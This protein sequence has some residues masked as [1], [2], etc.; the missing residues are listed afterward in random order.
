MR[1]NY[2][3]PN[4]TDNPFLTEPIYHD[5]ICILKMYIEIE[6]EKSILIKYY[7]SFNFQTLILLYEK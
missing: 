1:Y 7:W 6:K 5:V 2:T 3:K 4:Q